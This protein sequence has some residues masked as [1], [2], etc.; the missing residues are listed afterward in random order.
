MDKKGL[1]TTAM[2][3]HLRWFADELERGSITL[4]DLYYS[5]GE[6]GR[7][8]YTFIDAPGRAADEPK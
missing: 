5:R 1:T 8:S 6:G 2:I 7:V 3:E 4:L